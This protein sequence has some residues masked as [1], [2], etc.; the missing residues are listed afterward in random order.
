MVVAEAKNPAN[1]G[2]VMIPVS[3]SRRVID[4]DESD[5][6]VNPFLAARMRRVKCFRSYSLIPAN[7]ALAN[8]PVGQDARNAPSS[9]TSKVA[10]VASYTNA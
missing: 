10:R 1:A 3:A 6:P 4:R 8:V 9:F 2:S 5:M 7:P